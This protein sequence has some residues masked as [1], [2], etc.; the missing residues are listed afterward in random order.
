MV[1]RVA[2]DWGADTLAASLV[3]DGVPVDSADSGDGLRHVAAAGHAAALTARA[4]GWHHSVGRLVVAVGL[5]LEDIY[6]RAAPAGVAIRRAR[7]LTQSTSF[8]EQ[9]S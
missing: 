7:A 6:L 8:S 9:T 1:V 3:V 5:G 2:M 4:L